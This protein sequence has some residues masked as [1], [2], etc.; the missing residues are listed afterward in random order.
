[1]NFSILSIIEL[2]WT[3]GTSFRILISLETYS[4]KTSSPVMTTFESVFPS[5]YFVVEEVISSDFVVDYCYVSKLYLKESFFD[6]L[7]TSSP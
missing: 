6:L 1:M 4:I 5:F 3:S 2:S 7:I